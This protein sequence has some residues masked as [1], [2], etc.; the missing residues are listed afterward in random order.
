MY[1][2]NVSLQ[3]HMHSFCVDVGSEC[4]E[5]LAFMTQFW[6][7]H[8]RVLPQAYSFHVTHVFMFGYL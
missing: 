1:L 2:D 3:S 5:I 8:M 7:V 4:Y 6:K